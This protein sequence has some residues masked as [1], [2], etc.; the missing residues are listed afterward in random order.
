MT[1]PH[2]P[3]EAEIAR[4]GL[5]GYEVEESGTDQVI[6]IRT[7][8]WGTHWLGALL[9]GLLSGGINPSPRTQRLYLFVDAEGGA[10]LRLAPRA[11]NP[12]E[13]LA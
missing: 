4:L 12:P 5:E 3:V 1:S 11:T 7:N 6:L 2:P 10:Q 8:S 13:H 9:G